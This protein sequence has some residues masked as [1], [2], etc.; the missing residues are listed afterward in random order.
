MVVCSRGCLHKFYNEFVLGLRPPGLSIDLHAG[1]CFA[2]ALEETYKNIWLHSRSLDEALV[3][4]EAA[5]QVAWGDFEIPEYKKTAKTRD[6]MWEAVWNPG[7]AKSPGY[8]NTYPPL[9]DKCRPYFD[10]DGKPTFEYTFAIPL[11]PA[12]DIDDGVNFPLHPQTRDA[13]IYSGRFDML[14]EYEGRP[15][16]RD[17]KTTGSSIG[18]AWV[19]QW[20]LRNQ[21][22]GYT[23]ACRQCGLDTEGVLVRGIAIQKTQLVHAEHYQTF[24]QH[25][26]DRW[27]DQL[28][29]DLW[30]IRHAWDNGYWDYNF[31]D[32]CNSY[33][34]CIFL[35]ACTSR[36]PASWLSQLEVRRWNPLVK[37]PI[38]VDDPS[39]ERAI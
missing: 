5:F 38:A 22:M 3:R 10:A 37:N 39:K 19:N 16:P 33:G 1:A 26:L 32:A 35:D 8:F 7:D 25:L 15:T 11:E 29:R 4:A 14:G 18:Q 34:S 13:F 9:T 31:G 36:H 12:G 23:W 6:R 30:R 21:F 17:E 20:K 27:Y 24:S 2:L 28:R